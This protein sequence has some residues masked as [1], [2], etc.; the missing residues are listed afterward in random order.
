MCGQVVADDLEEA[1]PQLADQARPLGH[2]DEAVG[3]HGSELGRGPARQR[4]G[5]QQLPP[6]GGDDRLVG[7]PQLARTVKR[8]AQ[9]A[10][11]GAGVAAGPV[12]H[13][14]EGDGDGLPAA[15]GLVHGEVGL[16]HQLLPGHAVGVL[17][18]LAHV[19]ARICSR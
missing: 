16:P 7:H 2:G 4:L 19:A 6:L 3:G 9:G 14:P 17:D 10:L 1:P 13:L 12:Q 11:D 5:P 18:R 15:L 8:L